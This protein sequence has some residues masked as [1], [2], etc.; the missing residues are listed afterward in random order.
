MLAVWFLLLSTEAGRGARRTAARVSTTGTTVD[1]EERPSRCSAGIRVCEASGGVVSVLCDG[2][3]R[4][5]ERGGGTDGELVDVDDGAPESRLVEVE[6][7]HTNLTEV[8]GVV[9][10]KV[11]AVVVLTTGL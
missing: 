3:R 6:V 4:S 8:T 5:K 11:G 7:A 2:G 10:V 1:D 9:L